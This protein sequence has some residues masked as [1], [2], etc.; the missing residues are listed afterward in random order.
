[1]SATVSKDRDGFR[2]NYT[3]PGRP[4]TCLRGKNLGLRTKKQYQTLAFHMDLL[5]SARATASAIPDQTQVWLKGISDKL[6]ARLAAAGLVP[7]RR[8]C[9]G[10]IDFID[11]YIVTESVRVQPAT[12]EVWKRARTLAAAYFEPGTL[13]S[14]IT[15][16]KAIAFSNYLRTLPG[17]S[18][19]SLMSAGNANKMN[20]VLAQF[21]GR[22]V[23]LGLIGSN[24]FLTPAIR[25][26]VPANPEKHFYLD[27]QSAERIIACCEDAERALMFALARFG[28]LRLPSESLDLRWADVDLAKGVMKIRSPKL[29]GRKNAVREV[30]IFP[31][32]QAALLRAKAQSTS[33]YLLPNLRLHKNL[34]VSL[35]RMA[36]SAGVPEWDAPMVNLR[37]SCETDWMNEY[38]LESATQWCGNSPR[39]AMAH[40]HRLRRRRSASDVALAARSQDHDSGAGTGAAMATPVVTPPATPLPR[41]GMPRA[42]QAPRWR[43]NTEPREDCREL[44]AVGGEELNHPANGPY[45]T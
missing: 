5:I 25:R 22:A 14:D 19:A 41:P 42:T 29:R 10:L 6:H 12:K 34:A 7:S 36:T 30:P 13:L 9:P 21:L 43:G 4:R 31:P 1:M 11:E 16:T 24:P 40:Y 3:L 45:W 35:R 20:S 33:E 28:G 39:V 8:Q 18:S 44:V 17:K 27:P 38:D 2:V 15:A 37:A 26:S 23:E 32:L